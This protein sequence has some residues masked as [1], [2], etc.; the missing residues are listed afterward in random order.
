MAETKKARTQ[1]E[2]EK[3]RALADKKRLEKINSLPADER[4]ILLAME[5]SKAKLKQIRQQKAGQRKALSS[6]RLKV[7]FCLLR[8]VEI[9]KD[10]ELLKKIAGTIAPHGNYTVEM[11][12]SDKAALQQFMSALAK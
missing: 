3:E 11:F 9:T 1:D 8:Y 2:L 7:G 12:N 4:T 6:A 5:E 10:L